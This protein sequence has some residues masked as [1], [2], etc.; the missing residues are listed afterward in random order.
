MICFIALII[1]GILGIFS[2][3]HRKLALEAFD[4]V[5]R[6]MTLRK[7]TTGLDVRLKSQITG[8]FL[9]SSPK[10]GTFLYRYFEWF[11]MFFTLLL[12][13]SLVW[14]AYSGYNYYAYGNCNGPS[15]DDQAGLCLF[16]ITGENAQVTTCSNEDLL[17][18][19]KAAVEPTLQDVDL[20]IFPSY[21]PPEIKNIKDKLVYIGCY[22]CLNTKKVNPLMNQL[23]TENKDTLD[24]IFVHLP[25]HKDTEYL[26]QL[27]NCLYQKNKVAFWKFHGALMNLPV[28]EV[29]QK[30]KVYALLAQ[31]NEINS[32]EIIACSESKEA[33]ELLAKQLTEIK[34]MNVEGTPTIFVNEQAFIGPKPLRVYQRQLSTSI[35]WFGN[36]LIALGVVIVLVMLYFMVFR[37]EK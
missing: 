22:A 8:T 16:D 30:E 11:S 37:R 33:E 20:S 3:S 18:Q 14:T 36:G 5:F 26:S 9:E 7:C 2:A 21:Q 19:N 32:K 4:C 27:D 28:N 23:V 29:N 12:V 15:V 25:L 13:A 1:F 6:K 10:L 31:I 35:D 34:K 24:F 17:Q